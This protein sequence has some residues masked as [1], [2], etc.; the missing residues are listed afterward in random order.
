MIYRNI[1]KTSILDK[2][3]NKILFY[4]SRYKFS[5]TQEET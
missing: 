2:Y 1:F 5:E 4:P 3:I